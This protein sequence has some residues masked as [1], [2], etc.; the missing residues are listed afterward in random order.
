MPGLTVLLAV[1][2]QLVGIPIPSSHDEPPV[3]ILDAGDPATSVE[4]VRTPAVGDRATVVMTESVHGTLLQTNQWLDDPLV[5]VTL[6]FSAR[7]ELSFEVVDVDDDGFV[8]DADV[9]SYSGRNV[10]DESTFAAEYQRLA[11]YE[12]VVGEQVILTYGSDGDLWDVD[13][14][15][16]LAPAEEDLLAWLSAPDLTAVT[17]GEPVG[18]GARWVYDDG[19]DLPLLCELVVVD[20]DQ[21]V[22]DAGMLVEPDVVGEVFGPA[23]RPEDVKIGARFRIAGAASDPLDYDRAEWI[24]LAGEFTGG[25]D[26]AA[27]D[28]TMSMHTILTPD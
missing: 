13:S 27:I 24:S 3:E 23:T 5:D 6:A 12:A 28:I 21:Y 18:S 17:P 9:L 26:E 1:A 4:F 25:G 19:G 14:D 10:G 8:V 7:V 20:G 11:G 22:I 2:A 16:D 15:A